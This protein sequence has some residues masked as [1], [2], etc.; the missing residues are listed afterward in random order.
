M[1]YFDKKFGVGVNGINHKAQFAHVQN[2]RNVFNTQQRQMAQLHGNAAAV[3]PRDVFQEMDSVTKTLSR[4]NNLTMMQDLMPLAKSL[5]LGKIEHIYRR[6]SDSGVVQTSVQ[7]NIPVQLD[8]AAYD[9]ESTIKVFHQTG[10]GRGF[11]EME[12]Q[13][14][15]GFDGLL[16]DQ[17]NGVRNLQ[18]SIANH[19]FDGTSDTFNGTTAVGIAT[20]TAVQSVDLDATDLNVNFATN[21]TPATIR[22]KFVNLIDK[23]RITNN[24]TGNIT[25]Y[26]SREIMSN[27]LQFFSTSDI[28]F[29]TVLDNL[30][31]LPGVA[32]IKE[33]A[34]LSGNEVVGMILDSQYIRPLV[35]MAIATVPLFRANPFDPYNFMVW[36]NVGLEIKSDYSGQKG[37]LYAREIA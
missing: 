35:S 19:F 2:R 14:S 12:G 8:K 4:A 23:L 32:D 29:G 3:I 26:V 10:F 11:M 5:P 18:T 16:D 28:G 7:G 24:A 9:Y 1:L 17:A 21:T 22:S 31:R 27:F 36:A 13:K 30:K 20:S 25:F 6:A 37:V 33:D 34:T 15:E